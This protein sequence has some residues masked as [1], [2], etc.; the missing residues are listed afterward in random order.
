MQLTNLERALLRAANA[1]IQSYTKPEGV[2]EGVTT[3]QAPSPRTERVEGNS[4]G[5]H[6]C[7]VHDVYLKE[8]SYPPKYGGK[9]WYCPQKD[10]SERCKHKVYEK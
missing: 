2:E 9:A 4:N 1:F 3:S 8:S 10:G 6:K 7:P 5:R